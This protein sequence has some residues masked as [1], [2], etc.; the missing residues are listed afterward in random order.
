MSEYLYL[1]ENSCPAGCKEGG[2]DDYYA[3]GFDPDF[4]PWYSNDGHKLVARGGAYGYDK[5][6]DIKRFKGIDLRNL[7]AD[8]Y[9]LDAVASCVLVPGVTPQV[10]ANPAVLLEMIDAGFYSRN[11]DSPEGVALEAAIAFAR[12]TLKYA[13]MIRDYMH[14]ACASEIQFHPVGYPIGTSFGECAVGWHK[15]IEHFG[16]EVAASWLVDVFNAK[17]WSGGFGGKAWKGIAVVAHAYETTQWLGESFG[18]R[19]FLDRAFSLQHNGGTMFNKCEWADSVGNVQKVLD[20][21]ANSDWA[22]LHKH[23]SQNTQSLVAKYLTVCDVED[24]NKLLGIKVAPPVV[25]TPTPTVTVN[26]N[27]NGNTT[28]STN[29]GNFHPTGATYELPELFALCKGL[30]IKTEGVTYKVSASGSIKTTLKH[31]SHPYWEGTN[32]NTSYILKK[33]NDGHWTL[34]TDYGTEYVLGAPA[35]PEFAVGKV[36]VHKSTGHVYE[37]VEWSGDSYTYHKV[38]ERKGKSTF[39]PI[40]TADPQAFLKHF[41]TWDK[42]FDDEWVLV[43]EP[44]KMHEWPS[45]S[46]HATWTNNYKPEPKHIPTPLVDPEFE[47]LLKEEEAIEASI[48]HN[49]VQTTSDY[50]YDLL[51]QLKLGTLIYH[52]KLEK[53]DKMINMW[54]VT[55]WGWTDDGHMKM[56]FWDGSTLKHNPWIYTDVQGYLESGTWTLLPHPSPTPTQPFYPDFTD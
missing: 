14:Y 32:Y 42:T 34:F 35:L 51:P 27:I 49:V 4:Y 6:W 24:H 28:P 43:N 5:L 7:I 56:K 11:A 33:I 21:H 37:I 10:A 31:Y 39:N 54:P 8:F 29:D 16:H 36:I 47:K 20:A 17:G 50:A 45:T 25:V 2:I 13:P 22:K 12:H 40:K 46:N 30:V 48:V 44:E 1:D 9:L 53:N 15:V 18:P 38:H 23:A 19:E 3:P 52:T 41:V 26:T 55:F